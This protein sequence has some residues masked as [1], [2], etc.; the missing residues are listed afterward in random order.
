MAFKSLKSSASS[1][2]VLKF[3]D[4][5]FRNLQRLLKKLDLWRAE[6]SLHFPEKIN[7]F[8]ISLKNICRVQKKAS[9]LNVAC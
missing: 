4:V 5:V 6:L 1:A 3:I 8:Q 9:L 2:R 7:Y